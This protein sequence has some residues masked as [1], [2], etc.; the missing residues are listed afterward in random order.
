MPQS[1]IIGSRYE[2]PD[3][4]WRTQAWYDRVVRED[5]LVP[6]VIAIAGP[7]AYTRFINLT[8][9]NG[10]QAGIANVGQHVEALLKQGLSPTQI[11]AQLGIPSR[12]SDIALPA[13]RP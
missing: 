8:P 11:R 6:T 9:E 12:L 3:D 13:Q 10:N 4:P 5:R 7:D 2:H 1:P